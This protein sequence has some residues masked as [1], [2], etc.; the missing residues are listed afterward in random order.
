MKRAYFA[1]AAVL[2]FP[3]LLN[4]AE[5]LNF[6]KA[7]PVLR[8]SY[9]QS[10]AVPGP[11]NIHASFDP[12]I[13]SVF[14]PLGR[15]AADEL[16]HGRLPWWNSDEGI[17]APLAGQMSPGALYPFI[18]LEALPNGQ[19]VLDV[20]V[21]IIAGVFTLLL[22]YRLK[23]GLFAASVA[24]VLFEANGTFAW[25]NA[26][27]CYPLPFL[28][29]LL[30]GIELTLSSVLRE[31]LLGTMLVALAVSISI[32]AAMIEVAYLDGLLGVAWALLR[33]A[34]TRV[35]ARLMRLL[36]G[37]LL[38]LMIAMP[39]LIAFADYLRV[40]YVGG[41]T[42]QQG[43]T[44]YG[45]VVLAQVV[46]PYVLGPIF[47]HDSGY[48]GIAMLLFAICGMFGRYLRALR[49]TLAAWAVVAIGAS[50]GVL[51]FN[52]VLLA[53]PGVK[54]AAYARYIDGSWELALTLLAAFFVYDVSM[55]AGRLWIRYTVATAS[56]LF[57]VALGIIGGQA[58]V[59][60]ALAIPGYGTWCWLSAI[61]AAIVLEAMWAMTIRGLTTRGRLVIVAAALIFEASLNYVIPTFG[62]PTSVVLSE[63]PVAFLR[64]H[65]GLQRF[66]SFGPIFPNYGSYYG[67]AELDD[68]ELPVA[69]T[70]AN[71]TA[72][73]LDGLAAQGA[74]LGQ[75]FD[76]LRQN[77]EAYESAATRYVVVRRSNLPD[78]Q[79]AFHNATDVPSLAYSDDFLQI[80]ELPHPSS[81]FSAP[82]CVLVSDSRERLTAQCAHLSVLVR[83]ELYLPGWSATVNGGAKEVSETGEVF[84]AVPLPSGSSSIVFSFVPPFME[85]GYIVCGLA[86][87]A[88]AYQT[89]EYIRLKP[90]KL[91]ARAGEAPSANTS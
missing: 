89:R 82:G 68:L 26:G 77:M 21:Q 55:G 84:Q 60:N 57:A 11:L 39:I 22:A 43:G 54:Y 74:L 3:L 72:K 75:H 58:F 59:Q 6:F 5:L 38:G 65:L 71:Y 48:A 46:L 32:S 83:R 1:W 27:W 64:S 86:L 35:V 7:D 17:G 16:L 14:Q 10:S 73:H 47:Y 87:L 88:L 78:F 63:S 30:Y 53:I 12:S 28:P 80:Y 13:G 42:G 33:I 4:S 69:A 67:I 31:R 40:S 62:L 36:V 15:R 29:L 8:F 49:V 23:L 20:F 9:L 25:L 70:W 85:F 19:T 91:P 44:G 18:L 66:Y 52:D 81:Y 51:I 34:Q 45:I 56:V 50:S 24:G 79:A 37:A 61:W 41:H 90:A 76:Q 2:L